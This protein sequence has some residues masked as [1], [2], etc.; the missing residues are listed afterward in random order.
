LEIGKRFA[1]NVGMSDK[2]RAPIGSRQKTHHVPTRMTRVGTSGES[3]SATAIAIETTA[4]QWGRKRPDPRL[5]WVC[6]EWTSGDCGVVRSLKEWSVEMRTRQVLALI[7]ALSVGTAIAVA[8][9]VNEEPAV[10]TADK[11]QNQ[12]QVPAKDLRGRQ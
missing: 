2:K 3:C 4:G 7:L 8:Q 11:V 1:R 6:P 10:G 12:S 5:T 9:F